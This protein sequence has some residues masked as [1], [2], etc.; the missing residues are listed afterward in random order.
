M[1]LI[2]IERYTLQQRIEIVKIHYKN[3][4]NFAET[5]RKVETFL[6]RLGGYVNKQNC[7]IWASENSKMIIKRPPL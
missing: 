2:K 1:P 6:G 3:S 4:E 7:R 5:V